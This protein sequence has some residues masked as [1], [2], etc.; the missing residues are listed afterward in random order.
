MRMLPLRA[1]FVLRHILMARYLV[2][3]CL[4]LCT[5]TPGQS[6]GLQFVSNPSSQPLPIPA[7]RLVR[8]TGGEDAQPRYGT[9]ARHEPE[10]TGVHGLQRAHGARAEQPAGSRFDALD[11]VF[12]RLG[13]LIVVGVVLR[14]GASSQPHAGTLARR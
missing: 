8:A 10:H 2:V 6:P 9:C 13:V 1:Y 3:S 7:T 14:L 11:P 5:R 4:W 12:V